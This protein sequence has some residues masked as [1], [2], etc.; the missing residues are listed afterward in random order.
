MYSIAHPPVSGSPLVDGGAVGSTGG[1]LAPFMTLLD[2]TSET[3][4]APKAFLNYIVFDRDYKI[5]DGG[6][7]R[8]TEFAKEDGNLP[9]E[10]HE[11]LAKELIIKTPGYVYIY[12]SNDNVALGGNS[13]EVYFDD[14]NV[15]HVKS[16]IIQAED[17][18]PFGLT[19]NSYKREKSVGNQYAYNGKEYLDELN[20]QWL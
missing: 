11:T 8:V 6:Y 2:K 7:I 17:Y 20:I 10:D 12:L 3:G 16:P 15:E 13:V 9:V 5:V 19:F 1:A 18:Y 4:N 14:F